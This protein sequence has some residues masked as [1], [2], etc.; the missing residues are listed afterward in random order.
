MERKGGYRRED[1]L[2]FGR[3]VSIVSACGG[4][5]ISNVAELLA[6]RAS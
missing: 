2:R 6:A 5:G 1:R 3:C 4:S